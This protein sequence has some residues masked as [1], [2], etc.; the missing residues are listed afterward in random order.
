MDPEEALKN[1]R[2]AL[3]VL[4][5]SV[6]NNELEAASADLADAFEALDGW[7]SKGGFLPTAWASPETRDKA[8]YER[9]M[10]AA[11]AE[12]MRLGG[13]TGIDIVSSLRKMLGDPPL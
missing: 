1:A 12:A 6:D 4:R 11:M 2:E 3:D 10:R 9:G 7:L 5:G 8:A 13:C